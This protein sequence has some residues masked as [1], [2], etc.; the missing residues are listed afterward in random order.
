MKLYSF[1]FSP[2]YFCCL[3]FIDDWL[4]QL[5]FKPFFLNSHFLSSVYIYMILSWGWFSSAVRLKRLVELLNASLF[6]VCSVFYCEERCFLPRFRVSIIIKNKCLRDDRR[7]PFSLLLFF[8]TA[9]VGLRLM[10]TLEAAT[11]PV[12]ALLPQILYKDL[13]RIEHHSMRQSYLLWSCMC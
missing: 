7:S 5:H 3:Y 4:E 2:V 10:Q 8:K 12:S 11:T 1:D 13:I 6:F 9:M